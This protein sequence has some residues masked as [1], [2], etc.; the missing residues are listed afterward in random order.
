M[1]NTGRPLVITTAFSYAADDLW[2]L[3]NSLQRHAPK[4]DL[5]ILTAA[6]DLARLVTLKD[7]FNS[8]TIEVVRNPPTIIR[9]RLAMP[10]KLGASAARWLRR[11]QQ[12]LAP[13]A[14]IAIEAPRRLGLSTTHSHFLIRRF[15]WARE[16][17]NSER[18]KEHD[19]IMLCDIRDVAIQADPFLKI[20]DALVTGEEVNTIGQCPIN[21]G[22][23]RKAYGRKIE[24]SLHNQ[25][26]LC[27]G[28]TI[29][30]RQQM[31]TYLDLFCQ[32]TLTLIRRHGTSQLNNLDQAIHNRILRTESA[33]NLMISPVNGLIATV[34]CLSASQCVIP[35]TQDPVT[36]MGSTPAVIH[37]YDR[38]T[39]LSAHIQRRYGR[40]PGETGAEG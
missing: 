26:I 35:Q 19:T 24:R 14:T 22:W 39:E 38:L 12:Q 18:W 11:R 17:L 29:G 23:I 31:M 27:A 1:S 28:V 16:Q 32:E 9:G 10:R 40:Q 20:G 5:L 6:A 34:G 3:A 25:P 8:V 7:A 15:F 21:R 37:Q 2:P 30:S 4:A 36:V 33:L 13:S